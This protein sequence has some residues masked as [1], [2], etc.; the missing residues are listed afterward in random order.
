MS[1]AFA[2]DKDGNKIE[3]VSEHPEILNLIQKGK[4][5]K[6]FNFY[7]FSFKSLSN[8]FQKVQE[9]YAWKRWD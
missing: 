5:V 1:S 9:H 6:L 4:M 3:E 2:I 8:F 7:L